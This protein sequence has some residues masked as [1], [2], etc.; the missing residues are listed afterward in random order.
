MRRRAGK[1]K[2][3][4]AKKTASKDA[5]P[6]V[7]A[8]I[9]DGA[10]ALRVPSGWMHP[11]EVLATGVDVLEAEQF[12]S[13]RAF[14]GAGFAT[15]M[16][17]VPDPR[18]YAPPSGR[19]RLIEF[20]RFQ[21]A[22]NDATFTQE[23]DMILFALQP[24][25]VRG[26]L[27]PYSS[28]GKMSGRTTNTTAMLFEGPEADVI[29]RLNNGATE[30]VDF[31]QIAKS[32]HVVPPAD[33]AVVKDVSDKLV[34]VAK[35]RGLDAGTLKT[36]AHSMGL[37]EAQKRSYDAEARKKLDVLLERAD[38]APYRQAALEVPAVKRRVEE[39]QRERVDAAAVRLGPGDAK[40]ELEEAKSAQSKLKREVAQLRANGPSQA[41]SESVDDPR[42]RRIV[43]AAAVCEAAAKDL[44][45]E[46]MSENARFTRALGNLRDAIV[47][48]EN[49]GENLNISSCSS[50]YSVETITTGRKF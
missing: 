42:V 27:V 10:Y 3:S 40:A 16:V 22:E 39:V 20:L 1:K 49:D 35:G 41:A 8:T 6:L 46:Q 44:S 23:P 30:N 32:L 45:H 37:N 5:S 38:F 14:T 50:N 31:R 9:F 33:R 17:D 48:D 18:Y 15:L 21:E 24:P 2:R 36:V 43:V 28:V 34:A 25:F 11:A 4:A 29:L 13:R 12:V 7:D 26:W 47:T 19:Q